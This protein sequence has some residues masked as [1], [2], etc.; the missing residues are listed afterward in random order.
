MRLALFELL[1]RHNAW[2]ATRQS[3]VASNIAHANT[4][5]YVTRDVGPFE[6]S[7]ESFVPQGMSDSTN[8]S[9]ASRKGAAIATWLADTSEQ[10][11]S[12]NTVRLEVELMKL[13]EV[14]R[15]YLQNTAVLKAFHRMLMQATKG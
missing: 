14:S 4:P 6:A 11:L 13:S 7:L 10:S 3:A 12:G 9:L 2:L 15:A 1:H 5:G 8:F